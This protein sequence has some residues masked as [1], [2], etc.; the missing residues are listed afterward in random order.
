M[1]QDEVA[2]LITPD[3]DAGF[4]LPEAVTNGLSF[5]LDIGQGLKA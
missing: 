5:K 2:K 4:P 1:G 3:T